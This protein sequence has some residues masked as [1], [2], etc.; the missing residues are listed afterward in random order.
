MAILSLIPCVSQFRRIGVRSN[1]NTT[2]LNK[3]ELRIANCKLRIA[4]CLI[5]LPSNFQ[6]INQPAA[7]EKPKTFRIR[8]KT[9]QQ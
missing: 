8:V 4:N 6:P 2:R 5:I 9:Q 7:V 1:I 3:I